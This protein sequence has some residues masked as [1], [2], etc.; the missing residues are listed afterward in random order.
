MRT[1]SNIKI[2]L[3]NAIYLLINAI[4]RKLPQD[5]LLKL[6]LLAIF[7]VRKVYRKDETKS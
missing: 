5:F 3:R 6:V 4:L 2:Y 1:E 7:H